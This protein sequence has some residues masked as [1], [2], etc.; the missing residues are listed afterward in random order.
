MI[1]ILDS[2]YKLFLVPDVDEIIISNLTLGSKPTDA[3]FSLVQKQT[4]PVRLVWCC[5]V[6]FYIILLAPFLVT[7]SGQCYEMLDDLV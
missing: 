6:Q 3:L 4:P 1:S 7:M 2:L 5:G